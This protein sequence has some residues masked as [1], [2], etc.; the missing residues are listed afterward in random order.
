MSTLLTPRLELRPVTLPIVVAVLEGRRRADIERLVGAELP[1][2]WP[3]RA[4]LEQVFQ[5][6]IDAIRA[7][8][9]RRL[10]GDRLMV[11]RD[12]PL[13]VVGSV[14]FHGRPDD[15]GTCDV[16]YGVEEMS[17]GKGYATEA[18]AASIG[19]ALEQPE[20]RRVRASTTEWHKASM[21]VL[22]K[23]GMRLVGDRID[24]DTGKMLVYEIA[25][26]DKPGG[27]EEPTG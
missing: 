15:E 9:Q 2:T 10:W 22:E 8:P 23:V 13:R 26:E 20:C 6:S 19:W 27:K 24:P 21:R 18:L 14:I 4:L 3:T 12:A 25:R 17:Q 11:T 16:G 7:D 1:W 5:I